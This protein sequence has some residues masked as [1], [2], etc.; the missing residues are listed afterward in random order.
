MTVSR[1]LLNNIASLALIP[2]VITIVLTLK[3][4]QIDSLKEQNNVLKEQVEVLELFKVSGTREEFEA[5]KKFY[6]E[7]V[8]E[9]KEARRQVAKITKELGNMKSLSK[10]DGRLIVDL[11]KATFKLMD[12]MMEEG[13]A[14]GR[15]LSGR[16]LIWH[17]LYFME[18]PIGEL[19]RQ[20]SKDGG[21]FYRETMEEWRKDREEARR[22]EGEK[23]GK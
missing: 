13:T 23:E 18:G 19:W 12:F 5:L 3:N 6:E 2:I 15:G 16:G 9:A 21:K 7:K 22:K 8:K 10:K 14:A 17:D 4:A 11:F 1:I 20:Q